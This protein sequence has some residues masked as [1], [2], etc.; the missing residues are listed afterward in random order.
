[1]NPDERDEDAAAAPIDVESELVEPS[2]AP[3]I[4]TTTKKPVG[5]RMLLIASGAALA[6]VVLAGVLLARKE[7]AKGSADAAVAA[8]AGEAA[9]PEPLTL[10]IPSSAPPRAAPS[11]AP[12]K[13]FNSA[14]D[15]M[16]EGAKTVEG[17]MAPAPGTISDLPP[18]PAP[19]ANDDLQKAAKEAA[20]ALSKPPA[21]IDLSKPEAALDTLEDVAAANAIAARAPT[22]APIGESVAAP[23]PDPSAALEIARLEGSLS[24]HRQQAERHAAEIAA[25][26]GELARL[27]AE[28]APGARRAQTAVLFSALADRALSGASYRAEYDAYA[29]HAGGVAALAPYADEGLPTIDDLKAAFEAPFREAL[30][31][32]Y[33]AGAKGPLQ[34]LAANLAALVNL[35]PAGPR[36]GDGAV[37]ALSRAQ[38]AL[39]RGDVAEASESLSTLDAVARAPFAAWIERAEAHVAATRALADMRRALIAETQAARL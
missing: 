11:T 6:V 10:E 14:A 25:L 27:Q 17:A 26:R 29:A 12:D 5:R 8:P 1:M 36:T 28:G 31:I 19:G 20:K 13:I 18:P 16:K 37:A 38:D 24:E 33:R 15:I 39:A 7:L 3:T 23:G 35:R 32:S 34:K 2:V 9:P 22:P 21:E 30:E 4:E